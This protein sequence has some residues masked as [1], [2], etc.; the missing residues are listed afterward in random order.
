MRRE[1]WSIVFV[2]VVSGLSGQTFS[3]IDGG[4]GLN[5]PTVYDI[6]QDPWGFV[7]I[8]TRDGL[9]K[10]NEGR[11]NQVAFLDSTDFRR[12]NNVQ[13]LLVSQDS[14]LYIGLQLGGLIGYDLSTMSIIP[15]HETPQFP[16]DLSVISL[17]QS[18]NGTLWAGTAGAGVYYL[19]PSSNRW[20]RLIDDKFPNELFFCF[21]F[22][23]QGDTIWLATTGGALLYVTEP[24]LAVHEMSANADVG[25]YRKSVDV[26]HNAVAYGVEDQGLFIL[27]SSRSTFVKYEGMENFWPRDV[28]FIGQDLWVSTDGEGL[29]KLSNDRVR[30]YSKH[31][32]QSGLASNQF[33][34][35]YS[36]NNEVWLGTF[37]AGI[38][39]IPESEELIV[40]FPRDENYTNTSVQSAISLITTN[41][42]WVGYDG[43]GLKN[44]RQL[45]GQWE[46]FML[47]D[48]RYPKVITSLIKF[49][50]EIWIG[51]LSEG[52]YVL[53]QWG[54]IKRTY[55]SY[56]D[57]PS[58]LNNSNIWSMQQTWGDSLWIGTLSGLQFW[59]GTEFISP[60]EGAWDA[61]RNIMDLEFDGEKL[62]IG[63]EFEGLFSLDHSGVLERYA[64]DNSVLDL[65]EYENSLIIATEGAGI[66]ALRN[67]LIDTIMDNRGYMNA[68]SLASIE[69]DLYA[70]TSFGLL[71]LY[72]SEDGDW[73]YEVLLELNQLQV[74]SPNRK[75]LVSMNDKLYVGGTKGVAELNVQKMTVSHVPSIIMTSVLSDN[76]RIPFN[77]TTNHSKPLNQVV[78]EPGVKSIR[79]N[80]ELISTQL[81]SGINMLYRIKQLDKSWKNISYGMRS[82]D[83]PELA[84]GSYTLEIQAVGSNNDYST[85]I[86]PFKI[87]SFFWQRFWFQV[88][89]LIMLISATILSL[90]IYQDRKFQ[91]TKLQLVEM[92]KELLKSRAAQLEVKTEKQ[93]AELS[94]QLLKTSSRLE[95]LKG[96]K[97]RLI[98]ESQKKG[99]AAEV[100]QFLKSLTR[101]LNRELQSEN[102]WDH[103]ERNYRELHEEFSANLKKSYPDLTKGEIR[104]SYLLR[105]KMSNKEVANVLNVSPAAVEKAKYRL[106]KKL[107]IDKGSSLD[108]FIQ[109]L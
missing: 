75:S 104:L 19:L 95:L 30:I 3:S 32:K 42:I 81:R 12:S 49:G 59:D 40:Q 109:D 66:L 60:F 56:S 28:K 13:S 53:D 101:E 55:V 1:I 87:K 64:L 10:F 78:F 45:Q 79:F 39:I 91:S 62:W 50:D 58:G 26:L 54:K 41:G 8:G 18:N 47:F 57:Q 73:E 105:Q 44:Y 9:F 94:F 29:F 107:G 43:D 4:M 11:A 38:A 25:S 69:N 63:S 84:H 24:D 16:Q 70:T 97:D 88:M 6:E 46:E 68:Y 98:R 86:I 74:G 51:S 71:R 20:K 80:F 83:L 17:F 14:V 90:Y 36:L 103:F 108:N 52:I 89:C 35:I 65:H 67:G 77:V 15:D 100:L 21:D 93:K 33:Y 23:Q 92:E 22:A 48:Y 99:L 61:G 82:I 31:D 7:W 102:Y 37:N 72:L 76:L 2:L 5:H 106:K 85:L 27:D 34:G 96:F